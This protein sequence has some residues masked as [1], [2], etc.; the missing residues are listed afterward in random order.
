MN[1]YSGCRPL[2]DEFNKGK[3]KRVLIP[4]EQRAEIVANIKVGG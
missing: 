2:T 3:G 1:L 4:Y